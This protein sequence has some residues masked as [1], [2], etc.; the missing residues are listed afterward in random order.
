M[1]LDSELDYPQPDQVECP[2]C[3][4]TRIADTLVY[5]SRCGW[6][7]KG[8]LAQLVTLFPWFMALGCLTLGIGAGY[9]LLFGSA[10]PA[11]PTLW[12]IIIF[13]CACATPLGIYLITCAFRQGAQERKRKKRRNTVDISYDE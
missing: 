2:H 11:G 10:S 7:L 4:L 3:Q 9:A 5:C 13:L 12:S 6:R 8:H 1:L